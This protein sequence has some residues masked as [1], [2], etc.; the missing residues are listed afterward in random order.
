M[1]VHDQY[2]SKENKNYIFGILRDLILKETSF[3]I[4]TNTEYIDFYRFKYRTIFEKT[5]AESL[6]ELNKVLIDE[7]GSLFINDI[8]TKYKLENI[9]I[10][11]IPEKKEDTQKDILK[12]EF[13]INSS[14]RKED[15][16]NRYNY[17]ITIDEDITKINLKEILIPKETNQLFE[18]PTVS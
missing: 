4:D 2:F 10:Q 11:S 1:S 7:I 13:H 3:D 12:N 18:N 6:S 9:Q 5:N 14:D 17:S 16:L 15:S 8:Q